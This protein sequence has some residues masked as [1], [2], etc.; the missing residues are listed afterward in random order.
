MSATTLAGGTVVTSLSPPRLVRGD[1]AVSAGRVRSVGRPVEAGG[2]RVD[3]S[4]RLVLPGLVCAHHHLYSTLARGMPG[5]DPAPTT[6]LEILR[7]LWWRLD[8]A[9][10]LPAVWLSARAGA[11]DAL[12]A[13][14][15]TILDHHA[16]PGAIEGSLDEVG[17]A[18]AGLGGRAVLCYEVTDRDGPERAEAGLKE[19][20][21]FAERREDLEGGSLLRA[22]VG[23]HASFTLSEATLAAC[24]EAARAL[25]T[26]LHIHVAEDEVDQADAGAR[27]G[28]SVVRR[29]AG[30]GALEER[31]VL[32]HG[33]H[34]DRD[35]IE[36]VNESA[37]AVVHNPRSNMNNRVGYAPV[38]SL[39]RVA[40]GTDGIGG[41]M[42]SEAQAAYWRAREADPEVPPQW[43]LDR[44]SESARVAGAAFGEPLLGQIV[45]GA[46]A[47]VIVLDHCSPTPL[48]ESSLGGHMVFG[49]SARMV[50]DVFVAGERV[51]RDRR[52][53]RADQADVA[54]RS[55][56]AAVRLWRRVAAMDPHPFEPA[57]G[58]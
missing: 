57:G 23:A 43:A 50:T 49:M 18:V 40:L 22:M 51:V 48:D 29:L 7:G 21:R 35:E 53:T 47:D 31:A 56:E 3:C 14:T 10:D 6:F 27:F 39:R 44:L 28:R 45:E 20:R 4:G 2:E 5:P 38:G 30:A 24:V 36:E 16:S 1:V 8:R 17:S 33:V 11:A 52:L 55:R 19:N 9:L 13:G 37:A 34:L 54:A 42:L 41:D 58:S 15:T 25:E 46:P 26:G 12:L 32:A